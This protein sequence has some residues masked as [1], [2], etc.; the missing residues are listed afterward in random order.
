MIVLVCLI[1]GE[2]AATGEN[3]FSEPG[4]E[5][6]QT[7]GDEVGS[8][9]LLDFFGP[10]HN[11]RCQDGLFGRDVPDDTGFELLLDFCESDLDD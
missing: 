8:P 5:R 6:S 7:K 1:L 2:L 11:S 9:V 4:T 10:R 3:P